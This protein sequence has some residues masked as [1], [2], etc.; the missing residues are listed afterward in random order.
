[1][2]LS[3]AWCQKDPRCGPQPAPG[4][5]EKDAVLRRRL[6]GLI[7]SRESCVHQNFIL[8][9]K[10]QRLPLMIGPVGCSRS[11]RA[12]CPREVGVLRAMGAPPCFAVL[13]APCLQAASGDVGGHPWKRCPLS[14]PPLLTGLGAPCWAEPSSLA[15]GCVCSRPQAA[16]AQGGISLFL[17][18]GS[19]PG[20][21]I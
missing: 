18:F 12:P 5:D 19:L 15:A 3:Q 1:M 10:I 11:R 4:A 2:L 14:P 17:T 13:D 21:W 8:Q 7:M 6:W 9:T 16:F 20:T